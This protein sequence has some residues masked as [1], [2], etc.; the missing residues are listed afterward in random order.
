MAGTDHGQGTAQSVL[1]INLGTSDI[2][3]LANQQEFQTRTIPF[4]QIKWKKYP[5]E[6]LK[7]VSETVNNL[8]GS[9]K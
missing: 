3:R 7:I 4:G 5:S 6:V 2:R 9:C 1:Q 8:I